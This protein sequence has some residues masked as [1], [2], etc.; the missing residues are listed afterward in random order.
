MIKLMVGL[1]VLM[2][3][4]AALGM[5][6]AWITKK[7]G[8]WHRRGGRAFVVGMAGAL[9]L[10]FIVSFATGNIFLFFVGLFSTYLVF[11]GYRLAVARDSIRNTLDKGSSV[12]MIFAG[13]VMFAFSAYSFSTDS[14]IAIILIVFGL[15]GVGQGYSDFRRGDKWP[16]GKER[17]A[18]HL[19][20]MGG[21]S[22]ATVTAVLVV[23]VQTNPAWIA[24]LVPTLI[25]S[26][27]ISHWTK[28]TLGPSVRT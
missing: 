23:N 21:A 15:I 25:G 5:I 24:W 4:I 28:K 26:V 1:H 27:A 6:T 18:L 14:S 12:F 20:R 8:L 13:L 2:G 19:G 16:V 17:I 10:A 7:G 9:S 3:S 11:T 22:I